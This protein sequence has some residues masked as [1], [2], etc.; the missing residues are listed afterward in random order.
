MNKKN[1]SLVLG[2][3]YMCFLIVLFISLPVYVSAESLADLKEIKIGSLWELT[4]PAGPAGSVA[5]YRGQQIAI[6]MTNE[7]GG[8]LGKYKV[9]AVVADA[10]SSPD[11]GL[12]EAE[13][14]INIEKVPIII[15]LLS[16][17]I[18]TP[19]APLCEK[20]KT[21]LFV[22]I[23]ISE[24]V[25]KDRHLRYAFRMHPTAPQSAIG[26]LDLIHAEYQKFGVKSPKDLKVA[27][28]SE[29]GP[30]GTSCSKSSL[31][32]IKELGLNLVA[33]E[34]Y[35]SDIQDMSGLITRIKAVEPDA[36]LHMAYFPD[37]VLLCRQGRE[38]G[39]KT[40]AILGHGAGY[41]DLPAVAKSVGSKLVEYF[42]NIEPPVIQRMD[43]K[44]LSPETAKL[45][46][47]FLKRVKEKYNDSDPA[48]HYSTGFSFTWIVLN[49]IIPIAI[50]KYKA[51]TGD[52][53]RQAFMDLKLPASM[54]P[55]GYETKFAPQDHEMAGQN[56]LSYPVVT[57]RI[58]DSL[59]TVWPKQARSRDPV[60]PFPSDSPWAK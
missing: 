34:K 41:S 38:L 9:K 13:R 39:L 4:G 3:I 15:G 17:A 45:N 33:H 35:A 28:V 10:Q 14:L 52:T 30:F 25:F 8:I 40:K 57:Q 49:H 42:F 46:A 47:E 27:I 37:I 22:T 21:V 60:I 55:L 56:I 43:P 29:D 31:G 36:I 26:T 11:I 51:V 54:H 7:R 5:G 18:A 48:V 59:Y 19:L 44:R 2:A 24:Y 1:F 50:E 32:R 23:A 16:S 58:G 12:R 20:N 6:D 53:I